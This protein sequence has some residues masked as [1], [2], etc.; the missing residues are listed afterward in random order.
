VRCC[1]DGASQLGQ[2]T[3]T[4]CK[5]CSQLGWAPGLGAAKVCADSNIGGSAQGDGACVTSPTPWSVA[6]RLCV[7]LGARLCSATELANGETAATGCNHD[8][9]LIWSRTPCN[10]PTDPGTPKFVTVVGNPAFNM[11]SECHF[12]SDKQAKVRVRSKLEDASL[13]FDS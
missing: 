9:D 11:S 1:A 8:D 13:F 6:E 5:T 10:D 7:D 4:S 12:A 3:S 2:L